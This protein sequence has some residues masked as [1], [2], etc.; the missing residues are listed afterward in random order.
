MILHHQHV[1]HVV[2][3]VYNVHHHLIVHYVMVLLIKDNY[4]INELVFVRLVIMMI[5]LV[6]FVRLVHLG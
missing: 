1:Y 6:L 4:I 5:G 2:I 3:I